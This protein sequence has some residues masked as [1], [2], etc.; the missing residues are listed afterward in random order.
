MNLFN[1]IL[2][3][4]CGARYESISKSLLTAFILFLALHTA[5]IRLTVA[6]FI[7]YLASTLFSVSVMWQI[8]CGN[9]LS[10]I[11]QGM[12]AVPFDRKNL[13]FSAV[14]ALSGYTLTTKTAILWSIFFA[15]SAWN[16]SELLTALLCGVHACLVSAAVFLLCKKKKLFSSLFRILCI[17]GVL[18]LI[19]SLKTV[20]AMALAG[21][22]GA[23]LYL[24]FADAYRLY[25]LPVQKKPIRY[26][27][28]GG[29]FLLYL[30]RYLRR[31]KN[32]LLNTAG[33][34]AAA[35]FLP[36]LFRSSEELPLL[37]F[38]FPMLCLNTPLCTLLSGSP[39]LEQSIRALPGQQKRFCL[40]YCL[41]LSAVNCSIL[42]VYLCAWQIINGGIHITDAGCALLF[43][44]LN[45]LLSVL[46]EWF[47]PIRNWKTES[48]L[49]H[50][51]RKYIVPLLLTA[52]I[53]FVEILKC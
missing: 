19:R 40:P 33:L 11:L 3:Q 13:V 44:I 51:P 45:A 26:T 22:A 2:R 49:W 42:S 31:N 34:C 36:L 30:L 9:R 47:F 38:G 41:F 50:H 32:H 10:E 16:I 14:F 18:F 23:L 8:L 39:D 28:A 52:L 35:C 21:S 20:P 37:S 6:P 27:K 48:G 7:L 24:S 5:G 46:L 4:L 12:L 43:A 53:V 15:V 29:S 17:P 25:H 1:T